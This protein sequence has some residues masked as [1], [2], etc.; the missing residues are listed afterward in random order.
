MFRAFDRQLWYLDIESVEVCK[1]SEEK[2]MVIV[3]ALLHTDL[4][5]LQATK[6][7]VNV[8]PSS[9]I[10]WFL[11]SLLYARHYATFISPMSCIL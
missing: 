9:I 2:P 4:E 1:A 6:H 5:H 8:S 11:P 3:D 7:H 10:S